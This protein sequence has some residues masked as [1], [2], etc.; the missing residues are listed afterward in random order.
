M[1]QSRFTP[2]QMVAV[3]QEVEAGAKIRDVCRRHGITETT[4][5][6]WRRKYGSL[7]VPEARRLGEYVSTAFRV[8]T[9]NVPGST[10]PSSTMT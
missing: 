6:R 4:F 2:D 5:H 3:L 8:A 1:R 7:P 9:T 10:Y